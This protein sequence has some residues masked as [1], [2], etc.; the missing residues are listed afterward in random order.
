MAVTRIDRKTVV[1]HLKSFEGRLS[2]ARIADRLASLA[3]QRAWL[4]PLPS[5]TFHFEIAFR[6]NVRRPSAFA[7][8]TTVIAVYCAKRGLNNFQKT[9]SC[10]NIRVF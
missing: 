2:K 8:N 6:H 4:A 5:L 7:E 1:F 9:V 3:A 10:K